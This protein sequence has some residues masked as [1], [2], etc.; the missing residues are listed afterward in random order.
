M[1]NYYKEQET[2]ESLPEI[3]KVKESRFYVD[4]CLV[5]EC[6]FRH[7]FKKTDIDHH[8]QMHLNPDPRQ[9][10]SIKEITDSLYTIIRGVGGMG[11]S[12]LTKEIAY[13][14]AKGEILEEIEYLFLINFRSLNTF[15]SLPTFLSILTELFGSSI[16]ESIDENSPNCCFVFDGADEYGGLNNIIEWDKFTND[17]I[18][19]DEIEEVH[20]IDKILHSVLNPTKYIFPGRKLIMTGR[21]ESCSTLVEMYSDTQ[22]KALDVLGFSES[23]VAKYIEV[24]YGDGNETTVKNIKTKLE[25]SMHL[26]LM[27]RIPIYLH[28]ICSL[29]H[30]DSEI[31]FGDTPVELYVWQLAFLFKN[32]LKGSKM[33]SVKTFNIFSNSVARDYI[34]VLAKLVYEMHINRKFTF[35]EEELPEMKDFDYDKS[36]MIMKVESDVGSATYQFF[37]LTMAEFLSAVHVLIYNEIDVFALG[38][39]V[40]ASFWFG[41]QGGLMDGSKSPLMIRKFANALG[42]DRIPK[43]EMLKH[44]Q[45]LKN[46]AMK[47][48]MSYRST[49]WEF[50]IECYWAFQN[51]LPSPINTST[52]KRLYI[53]SPLEIKHLIYFLRNEPGV[54]IE[55]LRINLLPT[56][57]CDTQD[58]VCNLNKCEKIIIRSSVVSSLRMFFNEFYERFEAEEA[59]EEPFCRI[60][61]VYLLDFELNQNI[62]WMFLVDVDEVHYHCIAND[63]VPNSIVHL[64]RNIH[65]QLY[66]VN[67]KVKYLGVFISSGYFIHASSTQVENLHISLSKDEITES[68]Y[69][70]MSDMQRHAYKITSIEWT[71]SISLLYLLCLLFAF[72]SSLLCISVIIFSCKSHFIRI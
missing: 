11:K 66:M 70:M 43:S 8:I 52:F 59:E 7:K 31:K 38:S 49:S 5:D 4:L 58:I 16:T 26:Q 55:E 2:V 21:P 3:G 13:Q 34:K 46:E 15:S 20:D 51:K 67:K 33:S 30:E 10:K 23:V 72:H 9:Q 45:A 39:D 61:Q 53:G 28:I 1:K 41:L 50:F 29:F 36:T 12:H 54:T 18:D 65:Q 48:D 68:H 47:R 64:L 22:V 17:E 44:F 63:D 19:E 69:Q 32:H 60:H 42:I 35:T 37:H 6:V 57:Q 24:F 14:W 25:E 40:V 62:D 27:S 56:M 71:V